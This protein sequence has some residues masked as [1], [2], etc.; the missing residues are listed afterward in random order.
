MHTLRSYVRRTPMLARIVVL[1]ALLLTSVLVA[2]GVALRRV[3]RAERALARARSEL[4]DTRRLAVI[5]RGAAGMAHDFSNLLIPI[6][7]C[8]ELLMARCEG[9]DSERDLRAI[10]QAGIRARDLARRLLL[11]TRRQPIR[12]PIDPTQ[13]LMSLRLF[14]DQFVGSGIGISFHGQRDMPWMLADPAQIER[15]IINLVANAAEALD[16]VWSTERRITVSLG[17]EFFDAGR[18]QTIKVAYGCYVRITVQDNGPGIREEV[19]LKIFDPFCST[20]RPDVG[21]GL[22]LSSVRDIVEQH[23]GAVVVYSQQQRGT[24]FDVY[25]PAIMPAENASPHKRDEGPKPLTSSG[26]YLA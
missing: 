20:K 14:L 10:H 9:A 12:Q 21:V 19:R 25:L 7:A 11:D 17:R 4:H 2:W 22:G 13:L 15:V 18:A 16:Q 1:L 24:R 8:S 5:G 3:H 26:R 6:I 23:A